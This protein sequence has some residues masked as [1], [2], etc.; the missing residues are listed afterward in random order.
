VIVES[1]GDRDPANNQKLSGATVN[2]YFGSSTPAY[3]L[4]V[5]SGSGRTW[6]VFT[7]NAITGEFIITNNIS[8]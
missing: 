7:Y 1:D 6:N 4:N 3:T 5:P 2:I 8:T